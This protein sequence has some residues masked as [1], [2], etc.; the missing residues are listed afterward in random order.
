LVRLFDFDTERN[1]PSFFSGCLFLINA[2]LFLLVW[3]AAPAASRPPMIWLFLAALF[4]FLAFD[5]LFEVH[6]R[7]IRPIR[8]SLNLS[9]FL[10]FAWVVVYGVGVVVLTTTFALTWWR[11]HRRVKLWLGWSA[12]TYLAGA[13]GLEMIG[14]KYY[15]A[16]G[17]KFDLVSGVLYTIE[18]SLEIAGLIMLVH[19]LLLLLQ[20]ECGGCTI[21]IPDRQDTV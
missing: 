11:L 9:G 7:L 12:T 21:V 8:E 17:K 5:E 10:F 2:L 3:L 19:S 13:L 1:L 15:E 4:V 20:S 16:M 6:E 14:A 18:E